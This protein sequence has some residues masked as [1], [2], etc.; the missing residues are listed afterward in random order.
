MPS[1]KI[2]RF[3]LK[4]VTIIQ[5]YIQ[6][7]L[8]SSENL[9]SEGNPSGAVTYATAI[10]YCMH[11]KP[12]CTALAR[13][14][15]WLAGG[16]ANIYSRLIVGWLLT[17]EREVWTCQWI[18]VPTKGTKRFVRGGTEIFL[19]LCKWRIQGRGGQGGLCPLPLG[20]YRVK[21]FLY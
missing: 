3:H 5:R 21:K 8:H 14:D 18:V 10:N 13:G 11:C 1:Q 19:F 2:Q 17:I 12:Y 16:V 15:S 20:L 4:E 7:S 6:I 9:H